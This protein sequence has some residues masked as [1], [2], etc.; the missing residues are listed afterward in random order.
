MI[1]EIMITHQAFSNH[2][3]ALSKQ[4]LYKIRFEEHTGMTFFDY[5]LQVLQLTSLLGKDN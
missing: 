3:L 5:F 4:K 1:M 2:F